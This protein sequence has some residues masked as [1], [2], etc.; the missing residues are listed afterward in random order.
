MH[1]TSWFFSGRLQM[2]HRSKK[3]F[4]K[5]EAGEHKKIFYCNQCSTPKWPGIQIHLKVWID[6]KHYN[7]KLCLAL[8]CCHVSGLNWTQWTSVKNCFSLQPMTATQ[9]AECFFL[10]S[11]LVC[12]KF[13][14]MSLLL[15]IVGLFSI[16]QPRNTKGK[17]SVTRVLT[18]S[19]QDTAGGL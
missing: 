17:A 18:A 5:V 7:F 2:F 9:L 8:N 11:F 10:A 12:M 19:Q 14:R 6:Y 15:R 3:L 4:R 16:S 1:S 13:L